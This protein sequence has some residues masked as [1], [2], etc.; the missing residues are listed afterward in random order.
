M[1]GK[2]PKVRGTSPDVCLQHNQ[3]KKAHIP[4]RTSCIPQNA[5]ARFDNHT[6]LFF[7][8]WNKQTFRMFALR[9]LRD[10]RFAARSRGT[11]CAKDHGLFVNYPQIN[12][13]GKPITWCYQHSR[14]LRRVKGKRSWN[15]NFNVLAKSLRES[16]VSWK[17]RS[18][19]CLV[20]YLCGFGVLASASGKI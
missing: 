18:L 1:V 11:M 12:E 7:W 14:D 3:E 15:I 20:T 17:R 10:L 13:V 8:L 19:G 2:K 16:A 4:L 6:I 9:D 5:S